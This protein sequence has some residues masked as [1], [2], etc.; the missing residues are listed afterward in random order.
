MKKT[1]FALQEHL[2]VFREVLTKTCA[3]ERT[4]LLISLI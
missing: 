4:K 3:S 1:F 2:P